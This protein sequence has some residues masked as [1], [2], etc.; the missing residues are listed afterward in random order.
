MDDP[1]AMYLNDVL[2]VPASMAGLPAIS[3]PSGLSKDNLPLGLHVI[4]KP[5][6]EATV[7]KVGQVIENAAG[8]T[9]KPQTIAGG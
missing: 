9:A 5:F 2:T 1:I 4:G 3:V 8:F 6:D 7:L